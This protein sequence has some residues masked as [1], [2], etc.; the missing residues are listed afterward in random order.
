MMLVGGFIYRDPINGMHQKISSL[1][2][3]EWNIYLSMKGL[4]EST[5]TEQEPEYWNMKIHE[6]RAKRLKICT[7]PPDDDVMSGD[8]VI[9]EMTAEEIKDK[10]KERGFTTPLRSMKKLQEPF[11]NTL[12]EEKKTNSMSLQ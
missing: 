2:E 4:Q 7:E 6:S 12:R 5:E 11:L 9:Y 8:L 3:N 10:L 1:L